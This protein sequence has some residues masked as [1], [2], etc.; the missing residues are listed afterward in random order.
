MSN[1]TFGSVTT[2]AI[3]ASG[4]LSGAGFTNRFAAPGPIGNTT[5][6]A[7]TFTTLAANN[8]TLTAS[9]PVLDLAQTWNNAAVAFTGINLD[10]TNTASNLAGSKMLSLGVGGS[11]ILSIYRSTN[12]SFS[13]APMVEFGSSGVTTRIRTRTGAGVGLNFEHSVGI[14]SNLQFGVGAGTGAGD[15][16]LLRDDAANI[17]GQRN[18]SNGQAY[19]LY[20]THTDAS[21]HE[22]LSLRWASNVAIIGTEKAGTGS[23][24]ALEFQTDGVTRL[25][26][27]SN[28][29]N[30]DIS[31]VLRPSSG[32]TFDLGGNTRRWSR[33][34]VNTTILF[35]DSTSAADPA[36]KKSGTTLQVRLADDT[37]FAPLASGNLTVSNTND[38]TVTANSTSTLMGGAAT[39]QLNGVRLSF[40][41]GGTER[42]GI[43]GGGDLF[44]AGGT[45]LSLSTITGTQIGTATNQLLG[46]YGATPVDRPATVADPTGGGTIDAE[47]RTAINEIIDRLQELGL[48]A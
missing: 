18:G 39:I 32:S 19:R 48:I 14:G 40:L 44:L 20:N 11:S 34:F 26:I 2:G 10:I 22:R 16:I 30:C 38:F 25:S 23:A 43:S 47:A 41:T 37:A 36:I 21:N 1:V 31:S 3:T 15:V 4:T 45:D 46:F 13:G 27:T 12:A 7:G 28:G 6:A 29:A 9:A 42:F 17:L 5:P 33:L 24:R 8:G 35:G